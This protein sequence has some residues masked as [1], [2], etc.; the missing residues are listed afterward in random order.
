MK[1]AFKTGDEV[2]VL[3]GDDKGK[4]GKVLKID[5][6]SDKVWVEGVNLLTHYQKKTEQSEGGITQAEGPVACCKVMKAE[7]YDAKKSSKK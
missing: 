5:R 2:V 4:R 6:Q 3:S 1:V 7:R